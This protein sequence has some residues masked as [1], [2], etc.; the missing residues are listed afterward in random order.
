M[1]ARS[2]TVQGDPK[3][4]DDGMRYVHDTV[5]PA[6]QQMDGCVGISMLADRESGRCIV[7][8]S[9]TD[10]MAMHNSEAG[11][12]AMRQQAID[13]FHGTP[14]VAEWD[15]AVLHRMHATGDGACSTVT[16]TQGDPAGL[17]NLIDSFR[18]TMLPRMEELPGF[19][20]VSLMVNRETGRGATSVTFDSRAAMEALRERTMT[21]RTEF[22]RSMNREILEMATFDVVLAHLRV[23]E[24]V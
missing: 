21:M 12:R 9:W 10:E 3:Y 4:L 24:T 7:T 19:C 14:E 13:I 11:V 2:T 22:L 8:T 1:Y 15:I 17:D 6:V 5:M 18:M 16:W 20:S 23:P